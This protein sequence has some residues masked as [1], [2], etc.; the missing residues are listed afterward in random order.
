M[1]KTVH[2]QGCVNT[3]KRPEKELNCHL[4]LTLRLCNKQEVKAILELSTS[5]LS[6]ELCLNIHTEPL[7]KDLFLDF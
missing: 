1:W 2:A 3:Q 5:W 7:S 6:V 4:W